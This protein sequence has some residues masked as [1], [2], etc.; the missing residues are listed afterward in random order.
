MAA[1]RRLRTRQS[2]FAS[3]P[4][5]ADWAAAATRREERSDSR[6]WQVPGGGAQA[7]GVF[8]AEHAEALPALYDGVCAIPERDRKEGTHVGVLHCLVH[9]D[10][11]VAARAKRAKR[12]AGSSDL[13]ARAR[14]DRD[15]HGIPSDA[16]DTRLH[17]G[18]ATRGGAGS[19]DGRWGWASGAAHAYA[20][21]S[22]RTR[23]YSGTTRSSLARS[24]E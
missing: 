17:A 11:A 7:S 23:M 4:E 9:L 12:P 21:E 13:L 18:Q 8:V 5:P 10:G 1:R 16:H 20:E 3:V 22:T 19:L 24:R 2:G 6:W 15:A 14:N